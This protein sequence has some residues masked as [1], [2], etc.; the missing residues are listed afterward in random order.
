MLLLKRKMGDVTCEMEDGGCFLW[1]P[2]S[3]TN[4]AHNGGAGGRAPEPQVVSRSFPDV[5]IC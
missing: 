3:T 4:A 2:P 5:A 1:S